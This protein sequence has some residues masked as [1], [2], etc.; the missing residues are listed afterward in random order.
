MK[1]EKWRMFSF[2]GAKVISQQGGKLKVDE[3]IN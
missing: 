3:K 1:R 2:C